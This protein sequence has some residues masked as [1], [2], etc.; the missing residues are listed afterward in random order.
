MNKVYITWEDIKRYS[1]EIA[2][3]IKSH[4]EDLEQA[5]LIAVSRGGLVPAQIIA[6]KLNIRD[7][8]VMKLISY[9][10]NNQR[11]QTKDISTDRLFDGKNVY[12]I[13]DLS[14]SGE[15]VKYIRNQYPSSTICS[16]L[17]KDCCQHKPDITSSLIISK[18]DWLVFPWDE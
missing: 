1:N 11:G 7:V 17:T 8:R 15:T 5:T 3:T 16:L 14:D 4:C 12:I 9:D 6:Y 10:E 18:D 13:D 2:D